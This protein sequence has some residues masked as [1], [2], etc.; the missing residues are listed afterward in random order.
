MLA[1]MLACGTPELPDAA[2][3]MP[4][5]S[6]HEGGAGA[7]LR[8]RQMLPGAVVTLPDSTRPA[9]QLAG[10]VPL[11]QWRKDGTAWVHDYPLPL[12]NK[13]KKFSK[14][15]AG[16]KVLS[17]GGGLRYGTKG[18]RLVEGRIRVEGDTAPADA[19]LLST[20]L[21][22][23]WNR[24]DPASSRLEPTV[25][26]DHEL[27]IPSD[28]GEITRSGLLIPAP[29]SISW[30]LD[31]PDGAELRLS[32]VLAP[33]GLEEEP[34]DGAELFVEVDGAEAGRF[35]VDEDLDDHVVDLS[36]W[37]GQTVG[38][39]L[40]SDGGSSP[41][42]DYVFVGEPLV[43]ASPEGAPRRVVVIGIDTLRYDEVTQQGY[44]K[45][46]TAALDAFLDS[47]VVF[48]SAYA[49]APRTRPSFRTSTTGHYPFAAIPAQTFGEVF[50][51]AGFTTAGIMANV[52][53]VPKHGFN[54]GFDHWQFE[55]SMD[56]DVQIDRAKAW[57]EP[58]RNR[59]SLLFLHLMDPH[60]FYRAPGLWANKYV[61]HDK[62]L[63]GVE[64]NR[65]QILRLD[66]VLPANQM[67]L[68][69]R[70]DGEVAWMAD[71]LSGFLAWLLELPGDT[72]IA[73]HSD[74]GEEFWDHGSYEHNHTLYDEVVK[75]NLWIRSPEGWAGGPHRVDAPVGLHD[76]APTLYDLAGLE[77]PTDGVS[78]RPYLDAGSSSE[79]DALDAS[80]RDRPLQLGH[81]MYDQE[82]WGA[83]ADGYKCTLRTSDGEMEI[84]DLSAD[85]GETRD[86]SGD[87][88]LA[89]RCVQRIGEAAGFPSGDGLRV[90]VRRPA[91]FTL[92]F[93]AP[94]Q[95]VVMDP[96]AAEKRR[97][98]I[99]WGDLPSLWPEDV[100]A[101]QVSEDGLRVSFEPGSYG[102]GT[103][104]VL[105]DAEPAAIE[106][107]G[108]AV[109][110][111][112]GP[113]LI[114]QDSVRD[115]LGQD[116]RHDLGAAHNADAIDALQRLGYLEG[117]DERDDGEEQEEH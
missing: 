37:A 111:E 109:V 68:R 5:T 51:D 53:L 97:A 76:M 73:I 92:V 1:L 74:H 67:W 93:E 18:W 43:F 70:Y 75:A 64:L 42:W 29:G 34:S 100:G 66:G 3:E 77:A 86:L 61:E 117:D 58:N 44:A 87:A 41:D 21:V 84:F 105:S 71:Q 47:S 55:N 81:L 31:V 45:D 33:L 108:G 11:E 40:R 20:T 10:Q 104:L 62:G 90:R 114:I 6:F 65:W 13:T 115:R 85:P 101:V 52:H 113:V 56:A 32:T 79:K 16:V 38:L 39:V 8:L 110:I 35:D 28:E 78:L 91:A 94:V 63:L 89:S 46:V 69:E 80:L 59:D 36:Q 60:N 30:T 116:A 24:L 15:P 72:L 107:D 22:K 95:A 19:A 7:P 88:E 4:T 25:F 54:D 9:G 27:T 26:V 82:L 2:P 98:N 12:K 49:P 112:K 99:E 48:D 106:G 83:V 57:L 103:L 23:R 14:P 102:K 96:E 17:S 50:R